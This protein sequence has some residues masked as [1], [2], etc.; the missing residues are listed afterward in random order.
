MERGARRI[1]LTNEGALLRRR[2]E[3]LVALA[4]KTEQEFVS[5]NETLGAASASEVANSRPARYLP[6][7]VRLFM[8]NI[9][10]LRSICWRPMP[11][12]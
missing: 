10:W 3:E 7:A 4:D 6:G 11:M 12:L 5:Q 1:A 9:H 8:R 2:A